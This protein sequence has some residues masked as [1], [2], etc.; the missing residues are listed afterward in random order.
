[1]DRRAGFTIVDLLSIVATLVVGASVFA[2]FSPL[3]KAREMA[4]RTACAANLH[5]IYQSMYTY[6]NSNQDRFPVFGAAT[7]G[8]QGNAFGFRY[9][10]KMGVTAR[11]TK[12]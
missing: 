6:S 2:Q 11:P 1:M 5:G 4:N 12:P 10:S 9:K 7:V 3:A 8:D